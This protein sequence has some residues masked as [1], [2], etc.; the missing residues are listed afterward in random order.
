MVAPP[1]FLLISEVKVHV[2]LGK[3]PTPLVFR[4]QV[5]VFNGFFQY[6]FYRLL[7]DGSHPWMTMVAPFTFSL[8]SWHHEMYHL[9]NHICTISKWQISHLILHLENRNVLET[10]RKPDTPDLLVTL[11]LTFDLS[12]RS[13]MIKWLVASLISHLE[14]R[15][16]LETNRKHATPKLFVTWNLTFDLSRPPP[17]P[18]RFAC[19]QNTGHN[20]DPIPFI[21]YVGIDMGEISPSAENG[22]TTCIFVDFRGQ[23]SYESWKIPHAPCVQNTGQSFQWIF[24]CF[25]YMLLRDGSHPGMTMVAPFAFSLISWHHQMYHLEYH[26]CTISKWRISH[27]Y[28]T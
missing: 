17:R 12:V 24:Q 2:N 19:V 18:Q 25:V 3:Y 26:K 5:R 28:L 9:E 20:S 4:T 16:V 15:N 23:S 27:E 1:A 6:F 11:N 22:G 8:I 10:Y 14:L 7:R 21:F 13:N